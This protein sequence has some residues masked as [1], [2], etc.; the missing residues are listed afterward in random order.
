MIFWRN[1]LTALLAL[2]L[3]AAAGVCAWALSWPVRLVLLI[4]R[5]AAKLRSRPLLS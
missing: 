2:A 5:G 4:V 3:P 1:A